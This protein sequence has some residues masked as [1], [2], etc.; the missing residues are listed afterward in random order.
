MNK[1][2]NTVLFMLGATLA[3]VIMVIVCFIVLSFLYIK[4]ISPILPEGSEGWVFSLIFIGSIVLSFIAYRALMKFL[5]K[6][7][8]IE[9]YFDPLF[10]RRRK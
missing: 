4:F 6:K 2:L 5:E 7:V 10:V 1:K 9:K 3:N 8:D